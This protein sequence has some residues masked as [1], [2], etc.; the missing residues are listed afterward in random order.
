M[1]KDTLKYIVK[2]A[3]GLRKE[4]TNAE[5]RLWDELRNR[6]LGGYKFRRQYGIGRYIV[7]FY[8]SDARLVVEV[9]GLIHQ[10]Q[11]EQD[12]CRE[13]EIVRRDI[14]VMRFTNNEII[15]DIE[16]VLQKIQQRIVHILT[17]SK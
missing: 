17:D 11:I 14:I 3:R 16:T 7:D 2:V 12:K 6:R 5:N 13:E 9:D 1:R 8:C 4:E 10:K 15:N